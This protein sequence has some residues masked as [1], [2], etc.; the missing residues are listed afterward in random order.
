MTTRRPTE[1]SKNPVLQDIS[2]LSA[3]QTGD[4]LAALV[5]LRDTLARAIDEC[6]S[7]RDLAALSR[8]LC[9]VVAQIENT[10]KP[11]PSLRNEIAAKRARRQAEAAGR[12]LVEGS[13]G[14]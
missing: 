2:V 11:E 8:Q 4:S 5:A 12:A 7:K 9:A 6:G 1:G 10:P 14:R 3:A 13:D